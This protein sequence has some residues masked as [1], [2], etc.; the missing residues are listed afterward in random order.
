[1]SKLQ[2]DA[3]LDGIVLIDKA[4]GWT[5]HDVV[6]KARRIIGQRRIGHT[7]TLDPMASG[8]LVLCLGQ[9]TRLV[10][11]LTGHEKRY[12]G[13]IRLGTTTTTD[14]SEGEVVIT[15]PVP[16]I[17]AATLESAFDAFRGP[18]LQRPPAFSAL[19]VDGKRAYDLARGGAPP[20][21]VPR[22]VTIREL[23]GH[24]SQE[25]SIEV[26]VTCSSGT[27]IRSLARDLGE[28]FECGGHLGA[29]RRHS[30]G[31]FDVHDAVSIEDLES[32]TR[33]G[34]LR[35]LLLPPD[36]GIASMDAA[37][38]CAEAVRIIANG[39]WWKSDEPFERATGALRIYSDSGEFFGVG[40]LAETGEIRP[41]KVFGRVKLPNLAVM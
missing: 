15:R 14:D 4:P 10:E 40:S 16:E 33:S 23:T 39:G 8:L 1:M 30:A 5:S 20:I 9:A 32:I 3:G 27:Y 41:S 34:R 24:L 35:D 17:D 18:I 37:L 13:T 26:D 25:A 22:P 36:D 19:K 28:T 7:G 6:A 2:S 12:T 11:Y 38:L 21:L 31:P 29:L